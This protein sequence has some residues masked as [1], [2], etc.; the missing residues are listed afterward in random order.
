MESTATEQ[1]MQVNLSR[2]TIVR[3]TDRF[4]WLLGR[5][6]PTDAREILIEFVQ[7]TKLPRV[8]TNFE[9]VASLLHVT[10]TVAD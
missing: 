9:K 3:L 10:K 8:R 7:P 4:R 5:G 2:A 1:E 6:K